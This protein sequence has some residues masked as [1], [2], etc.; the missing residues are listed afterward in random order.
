MERVHKWLTVLLVVVKLLAVA[1]A[2]VAAD[3]AVGDP[4]RG[5]VHR[6]AAVLSVDAAAEPAPSA[7]SLNL[8]VLP[9]SAKATLSA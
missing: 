4:L 7:S 6:A 2:A 1:L 3:M 9:L 8:L 5:A